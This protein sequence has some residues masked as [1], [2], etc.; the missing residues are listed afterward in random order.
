MDHRCRQ[1]PSLGLAAGTGD[2]CHYSTSGMAFYAFLHQG[3]VRWVFLNVPGVPLVFMA[4]DTVLHWKFTETMED[5][6]HTVNMSSFNIQ[7]KQNL[8][9]I[10]YKILK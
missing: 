8:G 3:W 2:I 9:G 10:E 5:L 7:H 6:Y 4:K 1:L